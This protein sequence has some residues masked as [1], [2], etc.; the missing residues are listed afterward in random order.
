M[1]GI[2]ASIVGVIGLSFALAF[3]G[4]ADGTQERAPS[5]ASV[6]EDVRAFENLYCDLEVEVVGTCRHFGPLYRDGHVSSLE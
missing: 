5:L 6:I 1:I 3:V 4:S 2:R